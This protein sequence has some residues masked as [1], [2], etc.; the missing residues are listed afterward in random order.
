MFDP[1][2]STAFP[3]LVILTLAQLVNSATGCSGLVLT[4]TGNEALHARL[5]LRWL[6]LAVFGVGAGGLADGQV[7]IAGAIA[8]ASVGLQIQV[9]LAARRCTGVDASILGLL[10]DAAGGGLDVGPVIG[11]RS[12]GD[13]QPVGL[14]PELFYLSGFVPSPD[15]TSSGQKL[16]YRKVM[17]LA[18]HFTSVRVLYFENDLDALDDHEISWPANVT[19]LGPV[20]VR[21]RHRFGGSIIWPLVPSF[22]S[23]RRLA[24]RHVISA[25]LRRTN[26]THHYADFSQG[27]A[28]VPVGDMKRFVFR[29]HDIVSRLYD[30]KAALASPVRA[31]GYRLESWRAQRWQRRAWAEAARIE[32]LSGDDAAYIRDCVP[33]AT[34]EAAPVRGTIAVD[35]IDEPQRA[36]CPAVSGSGETW[37]GARTA[38]PPSGWSTIFS[39]WSR[40]SCPRRMSG[41]SGPIRRTRSVGSRGTG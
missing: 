7:G 21:R 38:M 27:L 29:Q 32:T 19:D 14:E 20:R 23:A 4:M 39:R 15:A 22:V 12:D 16:A 5:S 35:A 36:S 10:G 1:S 9:W 31:W 8:A 25:E 18:P 33:L 26:V 11:I 17:E 30:R 41:S 37:P 40:G 34:V 24:A 2:F 3:V 28:P 13:V 6:G